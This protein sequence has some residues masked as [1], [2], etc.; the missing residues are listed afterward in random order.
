[1]QRGPIGARSHLESLQRGWAEG[2]LHLSPEGERSLP[3]SLP[4][5]FQVKGGRGFEGL[6]VEGERNPQQVLPGYPEPSPTSS[7]LEVG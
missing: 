2:C 5:R 4:S 6:F 1:M 3:A 7:G